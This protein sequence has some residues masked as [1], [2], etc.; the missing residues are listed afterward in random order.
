MDPKRYPVLVVDDEQDNL[1]AFRFN[2]R[3]TFDLLT[4]TSGP[5]ALALLEDLQGLGTAARR[6]DVECLS[7]VEPEGVEVVLLVVD[8]E[9][10]VLAR[11]QVHR[12][13]DTVRTTAGPQEGCDCRGL[14]AISYM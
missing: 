10:R 6:Q 4:A 14:P 1:D 9:D 7:E 2:F 12:P 11:V 8:D 5:E 3:K 13:T